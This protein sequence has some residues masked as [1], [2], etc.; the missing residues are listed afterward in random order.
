MS[1]LEHI[2]DRQIKKWEMERKQREEKIRKQ[3]E[4]FVQPV[5]TISRQWG[6]RGSYL[7]KRLAEILNYNLVDRE[8]I[9]YIVKNSGVRRKLVESLDEK[10]R[11]EIG[12]WMEGI[13]EGRY[14]DKGEYFTHLLRCIKVIGEHGA[15]VIVGR[16]ANFALGLRYG[17]HLRV[18]APEEI[19]M[20]YL[21]KYENVSPEQ[22]KEAIK[23]SDEERKS[24]IRSFY[25]A[26]IDDPQYYDMVINS[27]YVDVEDTIFFIREA[28]KAKAEKLKWLERR[29]ELK[30]TP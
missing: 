29:G 12:L 16:G 11:S 21:V 13:L 25:H 20:Q 18:V 3:E 26:D 15:T 19:R 6:S 5:V 30:K 4:I 17:F 28:I 27:A 23:K 9:D 8:I 10:T 24:F 2:V 7:A 1:S 14:V 22:A